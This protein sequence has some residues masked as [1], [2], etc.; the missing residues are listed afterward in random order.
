[1]LTILQS[2]VFFPAKSHLRA[3]KF[4]PE[5]LVIIILLAI[6]SQRKSAAIDSTFVCADFHINSVIN[7]L[8]DN[9]SPTWFDVPAP[10]INSLPQTTPQTSVFRRR[11]TMRRQQQLGLGGNIFGPTLSIASAYMQYSFI[12]T[13]QIEAGLDLATVYA[14]FN[15][16]PRVITQYEFLSPYMGLMIGYSDPERN[17]TVKGIYA[18]MPVGIRF[19]TPDN[20]YVCLEVAAT[21]AHNVRSAPL[22]LGLKMGFLFK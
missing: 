12:K 19:V 15:F 7:I 9:I 8:P 20:W 18:Y 6:G 13:A 17:K 21:T 22:F 10:E 14:G 1:M 3:F 2:F 4:K 5:T 16:Y 11:S